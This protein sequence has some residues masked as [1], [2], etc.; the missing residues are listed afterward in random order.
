MIGDIVSEVVL[1]GCGGMALE[2]AAYIL[3]VNDQSQLAGKSTKVAGIL[4]QDFTKHADIERLL[5]YSV[6]CF[7]SIEMITQLEQKEFL[8]CIGSNVAVHRTLNNEVRRSK[9]PLFRLIHPTAYVAKTAKIAAGVILAPNVFVGPGASIGSGT[10]VNV[11]STIGHDA[12]VGEACIVSPGVNINGSVSVE[13][14]VFFGSK[15]SVDPGLSV[16]KFSKVVSG[17]SVRAD[18]PAGH[19]Q[20]PDTRKPIKMFNLETGASLFEKR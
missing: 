14:G 2:A 7:D 13:D 10:I 11:G 1:I 15:S 18:I 4:S 20:L 5:G 3:D 8:I 6:P 12:I 16:A 9:L 17:T 19:L